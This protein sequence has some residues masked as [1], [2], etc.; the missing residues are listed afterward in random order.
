M[1]FSHQQLAEAQHNTSFHSWEAAQLYCFVCSLDLGVERGHWPPFRHISLFP[2]LCCCYT[3]IPLMWLFFLFS[4]PGFSFDREPQLYFDDTCVVPE[5]LEG[6]TEN[7]IKNIQLKP[8]VLYAAH[9][10][11]YCGYFLG[12]SPVL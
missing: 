6:K 1:H 12:H 4:I 10:I 9:K 8:K 2:T 11:F 3:Y 5:R 7:T